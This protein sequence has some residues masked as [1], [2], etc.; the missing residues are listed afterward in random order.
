MTRIATIWSIILFH[1]LVN[2]EC[3]TSRW[4]V[5]KG[6]W[7]DISYPMEFS[8]H[9]EQKSVTSTE[10][11]DSVR[12]V[13]PDRK[14]EFYVF[15]P[16]WS[17]ESSELQVREGERIVSNK[18]ETH[19]FRIG[20]NV[21]KGAV[22]ETWITIE[23]GGGQQTRYYYTKRNRATHTYLVFGLTSRDSRVTRNYKSC[24]ARFKGSIRQ[25]AD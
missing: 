8:V 17:G 20:D 3:D 10:G 11:F 19:D 12:F 15:S 25:Y 21:E 1:S 13:S 18:I 16:Q 7:F 2:A 5:F 14:V 6:A 22:V 23:G 4:Q 9:P 24:Y